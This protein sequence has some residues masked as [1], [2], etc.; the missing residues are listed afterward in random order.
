[1]LMYG[2][3]R[4]IDGGWLSSEVSADMQTPKDGDV[5]SIQI[6]GSTLWSSACECGAHGW[7]QQ[8]FSNLWVTAKG[9]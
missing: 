9:A 3:V 6:T 2:I 1:M 5:F 7:A 8:Y 4:E